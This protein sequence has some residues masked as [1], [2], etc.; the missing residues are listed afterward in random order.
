M[1]KARVRPRP[2]VAAVMAEIVG[3]S[4]AAALSRCANAWRQK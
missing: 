1:E 3:L 4:A 2:A